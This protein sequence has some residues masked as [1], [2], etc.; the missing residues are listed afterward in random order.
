[1]TNLLLGL[2]DRWFVDRTGLNV[3]AARIGRDPPR[4]FPV[5]DSVALLGDSKEAAIELALPGVQLTKY[6]KPEAPRYTA[7]DPCSMEGAGTK[8]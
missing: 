7:L 8:Y 1:M 4:F 3:K 2:V 6:G 5:F